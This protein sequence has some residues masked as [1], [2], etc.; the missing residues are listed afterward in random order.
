MILLCAFFTRLRFAQFI[1]WSIS[2]HP[3]I[4]AL[5][6]SSIHSGGHTNLLII[7]LN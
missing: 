5:M 7:K 1:H 2:M 4:K 3:S 6:R